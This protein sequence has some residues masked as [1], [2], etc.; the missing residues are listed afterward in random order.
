MD[1][2][3]NAGAGPK[4]PRK[5]DGVITLMLPRDQITVL[6]RLGRAMVR[7]PE[8]VLRQASAGIAVAQGR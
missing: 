2:N 6:S 3:Q 8:S 7:I 5:A 1:K 4:A